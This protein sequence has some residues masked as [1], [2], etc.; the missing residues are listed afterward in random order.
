M[1]V[2]LSIAVG[3]LGLWAWSRYRPDPLQVAFEGVRRGDMRPAVNALHRLPAAS[4][5]TAYHRV[6]GRLWDGYHRAEAVH[7]AKD[8]ALSHPD[9]PTAHFWLQKF[10]QLEPEIAGEHLDE[11]FLGAHFDPAVAACCGSYG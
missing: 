4:R 6:I 11:A 7:L 10:L 8:F 9:A 3:L 2:G 1:V 5:P